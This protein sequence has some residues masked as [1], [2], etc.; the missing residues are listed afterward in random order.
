MVGDVLKGDKFMNTM[1]TMKFEKGNR[2]WDCCTF[3]RIYMKDNIKMIKFIGMTDRA[4]NG[5]GYLLWLCT[6]CED[7]CEMPLEDILLWDVYYQEEQLMRRC[8]KNYEIEME[9]YDCYEQAN[10]WVLGDGNGSY[11][12]NLLKLTNDISCGYY[13]GN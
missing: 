12:K 8:S 5:K 4:S 1:K 3:Y 10:K 2:M 7:L 11:F 6:Y 9:P 13:Y